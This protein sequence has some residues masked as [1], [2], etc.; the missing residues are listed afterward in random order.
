M[1]CL[2]VE[3]TSIIRLEKTKPVLRVSILARCAPSISKPKYSPRYAKLNLS[4]KNKKVFAN[5]NV[6]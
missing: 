6:S 4:R 5:D 1:I 3:A 2:G